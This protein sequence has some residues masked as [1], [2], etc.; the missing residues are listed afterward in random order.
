MSAAPPRVAPFDGAAD[1]YDAAFSDRLL[2][3]LLRGLLHETLDRHLPRQGRLLEL[4]CGTGVDATF[5]ARRGANV[6]AGDLSA[7]MLA[8]TRAR[9][10]AACVA[11][12][13]ETV[14]L[15]L[16][17]PVE[18]RTSTGE[19]VDG[20]LDG[21]FDGAWSAF[22]PLNC[23]ADRHALG[24][25]LRRWLKPGARVVL[26]PMARFAPWDWLWYGAHLRPGAAVRRLRRHPTAALP[27]GGR[28]P[29]SYPTLR[30]LDAEMGPGL[31]RVEARGL[32][33][34]LP[35]SEAAGMVER[36]PRL[37]EAAASLERGLA[38]RGLSPHLC[39]HVAVVYERR[40]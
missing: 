23:V 17:R 19:A 28:L 14:R 12:R 1:G 31:R 7:E 27:G 18:L 36:L 40:R 9:A 13:V 24:E 2:G 34:L 32:G 6:I 11:D 22:G 5:M 21:C 39:D 33:V 26:V 29:L 4:G 16:A 25:A 3:R 38:G 10:E 30:Q 20:G 35:I 8:A 15:D 37:F